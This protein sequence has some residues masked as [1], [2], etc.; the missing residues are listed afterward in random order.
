MIYLVVYQM[1]FDKTRW[2][3]PSNSDQNC[4]QNSSKGCVG[5][6]KFTARFTKPL[7][8]LS[9]Y[10]TVSGEHLM[11]ICLFHRKYT[12]QSQEAVRPVAL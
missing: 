8:C 2:S 12:R 1:E 6:G 10:R 3:C 7:V 4:T 11:D 5:C 9:P